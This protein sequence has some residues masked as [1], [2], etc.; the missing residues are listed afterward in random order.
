MQPT[1][2]WQSY[3]EEHDRTGGPDDPDMWRQSMDEPDE[4]VED[5]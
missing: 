2:E 5:G 4:E 3:D 1:D